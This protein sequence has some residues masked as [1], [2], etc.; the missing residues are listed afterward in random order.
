MCQTTPPS[1]G[2]VASLTTCPRSCAEAR[3]LAIDLDDSDL[4]EF[5]FLLNED[6]GSHC[7][8]NQDL[9]IAI[10]LE[11]RGCIA[12]LPCSTTQ[13]YPRSIKIRA[14]ELSRSPQC[15]TYRRIGICDCAV[16]V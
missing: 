16:S 3:K 10:A 14:G 13:V 9:D 12:D 15:S 6:S 11:R 1:Y 2:T 7:V 8:L 4:Y 5:E